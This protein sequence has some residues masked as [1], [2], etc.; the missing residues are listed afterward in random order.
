ML[1]NIVKTQDSFHNKELTCPKMSI[2]LRWATPAIE[3]ELTEQK[4]SHMCK[5]QPI[6]EKVKASSP[7]EM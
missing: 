6:T 3:N 2:V 5:R 1:L 4:V 7:S